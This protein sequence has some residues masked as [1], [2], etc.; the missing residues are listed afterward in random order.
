MGFF[1]LLKANEE[2]IDKAKELVKKLQ[3]TFRPESFENPA[4][5]KHYAN[6]EAM[7]LDRDEPE[8]ITDYTS[9]LTSVHS[10][11]LISRYFLGKTSVFGT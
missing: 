11:S 4:L 2:Q 8:E 7:A 5:Q 6:V 10:D 9:E 1:F 3:F